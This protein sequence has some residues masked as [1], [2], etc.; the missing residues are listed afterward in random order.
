MLHYMD[1]S[2]N[3]KV[4]LKINF[5]YCNEAIMKKKQTFFDLPVVTTYSNKDVG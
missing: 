5:G 2:E 3:F 4:V 1:T